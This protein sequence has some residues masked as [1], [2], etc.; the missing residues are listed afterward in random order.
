MKTFY[1]FK[2]GQ[3]I[4]VFR[5]AEQYNCKVMKYLEYDSYGNMITTIFI[6]EQ[7][8]FIEKINLNLVYSEIIRIL[9]IYNA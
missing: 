6:D 8:T 9:A 2:N 1:Q 3:H 5:I 7:S 4:D